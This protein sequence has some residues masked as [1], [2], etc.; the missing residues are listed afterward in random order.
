[1]TSWRT[2]TRIAAFKE[3]LAAYPLYGK[4]ASPPLTPEAWWSTLIHK[5]MLHAGAGQRGK[6]TNKPPIYSMLTG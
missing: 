4:H 5:C 1:M 2:L 6:Y 3:M